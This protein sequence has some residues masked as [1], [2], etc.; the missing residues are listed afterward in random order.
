MTRGAASPLL[1]Q[2]SEPVPL[3]I[4]SFEAAAEALGCGGVAATLLPHHCQS[5]S[6]WRGQAGPE[7]WLRP[8]VERFFH[9]GGKDPSAQAV[10][11]PRTVAE[12]RLSRAVLLPGVLNDWL[13]PI[14]RV[15]E[16]WG[17]HLMQYAD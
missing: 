4:F 14:N 15:R 6:C 8:G 16:A 1:C 10:C 7:R 2:R 12:R 5:L 17:I 3:D 11:Q 13:S 9:P